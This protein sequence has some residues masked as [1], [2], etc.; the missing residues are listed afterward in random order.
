ET[1]LESNFLN[2]SKA[3]GKSSLKNLSS[4]YASEKDKITIEFRWGYTPETIGNY[5]NADLVFSFS[6]VAGLKKGLKSSSFVIPMTVT[7]ISLKEKT[8]DLNGR[9]SAKNLLADRIDTIVKKQNDE[10][11]ARANEM[12]ISPNPAKSHL[13]ATRLTK[14]DFLVGVWSL[15]ADDL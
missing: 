2:F 7:P 14:E 9:Y 15:Q 5:E 11:I 10:N 4:V 12:F 8:L 13:K 1:L 6:L 3:E